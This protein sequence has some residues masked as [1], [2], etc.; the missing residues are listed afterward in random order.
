MDQSRKKKILIGVIGISLFT[1]GLILF[2]VGFTIKRPVVTFVNYDGTVLCEAPTAI[3]KTATYTGEKPTKP[4]DK[5]GYTNVFVGWEP[6]IEDVREDRTV[7]AV[8]ESKIVNYK[9]NL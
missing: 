5:V 4:S 3:G 2:I 7:T 1:I 9:S 6:S 8:Y